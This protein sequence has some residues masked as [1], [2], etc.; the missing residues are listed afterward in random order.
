MVLSVFGGTYKDE[1]QLYP[2]LS[3]SEDILRDSQG[4][5]KPYSLNIFI[6]EIEP[7]E[8]CIAAF[9][10]DC[11]RC[12]QHFFCRNLIFYYIYY[13]YIYSQFTFSSNLL[14]TDA[15]EEC[16]AL[17]GG[18]CILLISG[19]DLGSSAQWKRRR[20]THWS[21]VKQR[22]CG[23]SVMLLLSW[24]KAGCFISFPRNHFLLDLRMNRHSWFDSGNFIIWEENQFPR[25]SIICAIIKSLTI[26]T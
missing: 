11:I 13:I 1:I 3:I 26:H 10:G 12:A 4:I 15:S 21:S 8:L 18:F 19:L 17:Y 7:K 22:W 23:H 5:P 14:N 9:K 25:K 24:P 6:F 2:R 16:D 20:L